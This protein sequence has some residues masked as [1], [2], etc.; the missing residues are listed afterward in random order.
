MHFLETNRSKRWVKHLVTAQIHPCRVFEKL[1]SLLT[2]SKHLQPL[3]SAINTS[4]VPNAK[5]QQ[6]FFTINIITSSIRKSLLLKTVSSFMFISTANSMI[7]SFDHK[8]Y[9]KQW[10]GNSHR[11]DGCMNC[12]APRWGSSG[13]DSSVGIVTCYRL[14]IWNANLGGGKRY[15]L[16]HTSPDHL[17]A[18]PAS[19]TI[20]I[21]DHF[22]GLRG[23]GMV[24]T[25]HTV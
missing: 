17:G 4:I 3:K 22:C 7:N 23:Q 11:D 20:G 13:C 9:V 6:S 18:H 5:C 1:V 15:S 24:L 8:N 25:A 21:M 12:S 10:P 16:L 19:C 14:D 2:G